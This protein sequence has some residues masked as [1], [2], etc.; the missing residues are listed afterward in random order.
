MSLENTLKE[1]CDIKGEPLD[2][3]NGSG[4][5][6]GDLENTALG[7]IKDE[8]INEG[9]SDEKV[10][11]QSIDTTLDLNDCYL[12]LKIEGNTIDEEDFRI[13]NDKYSC[14]IRDNEEH[15]ADIH[16]KN[17][18]TLTIN[19]GAHMRESIFFV[20]HVVRILIKRVNL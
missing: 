7:L 5:A 20:I 15:L 19:I 8:Y 16:V 12:D 14:Y 3:E 17:E 11:V 10:E 18:E 9:Y 13:K 1:N 6:D 4:Q 2:L